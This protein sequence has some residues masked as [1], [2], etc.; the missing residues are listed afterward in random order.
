MACSTEKEPGFWRGGNC[1][2]LIRCCADDRLRRDEHEGV[3]DE[4]AH[5]IARLVLRPLERIGA[6]V[7]QQRQAEL[8]QRLRPDR[9]GPA[10]FCSMKTAFHCS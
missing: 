10:A 2:K 7:E 5:V 8:H 3:L 6:Q 9:R 4:P 1:W